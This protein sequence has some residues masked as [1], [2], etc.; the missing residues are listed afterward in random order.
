MLDRLLQ[1]GLLDTRSYLK[2]YDAPFADK[3]LQD[4]DNYMQQ[5]Q[6]GQ[7]PVA[8]PQVPGANQQQAQLAA[9]IMQQPGGQ[10]F[11]RQSPNQQ[12]TQQ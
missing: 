7:Q 2:N 8:P 5:I 4:Y 9:Q 11:T 12:F 10:L 3:L 1:M 6:Q